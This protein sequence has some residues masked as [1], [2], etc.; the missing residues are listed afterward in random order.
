[1]SPCWKPSVEDD[2]DN[3]RNRG[4]DPSERVEGLLWYKD[5]GHHVNGEFSIAAVQANN[6]LEDQSQLE[7]GPIRSIESGPHGTFVGIY[8]G[9]AGPE[10]GA[11]PLE[12]QC[13]Q[14]PQLRFLQ[15]KKLRKRSKDMQLS[16]EHNA[17][18][19]SV[20]EE[21]HSLHPDDPQIVVLKNKVWRV[22]G[23]IKVS[24]SIGDAY[25][26]KIEFN[27]E[28]LWPKFRQPE[29]FKKPIL[30]AE[31][32]I[33]VQKLHPKDQFLIFASD[34]LWEHLSNQEA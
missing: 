16:A 2:R 1:L 33:L 14:W 18:Q 8:D 13:R 3:S 34:G 30:V 6:I 17:N 21:L 19:E 7:S 31:P 22:K 27:R 15:L 5:S 32:S 10:A 12:G 23:K 25:L 24:R 20:P 26:K 29:P 11:E 4:G 28:P 9:H